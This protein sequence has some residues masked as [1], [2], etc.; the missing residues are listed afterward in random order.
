M[1]ERDFKPQKFSEKKETGKIGEFMAMQS[2]T[3]TCENNIKYDFYI[4][5]DIDIYTR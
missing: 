2:E 1:Q 5:I 3:G 4:E